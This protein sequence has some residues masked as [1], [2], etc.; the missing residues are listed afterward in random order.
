MEESLQG[1]FLIATPPLRDPHFH[2]AVVLIVE[3]NLD[4]AMGMIVNRPSGV[5]I[6]D[7]LSD[8][9][10]VSHLDDPVFIGGPVE[11][12]GLLILHNSSEIDPRAESVIPG[13]YIS[14]SPTAFENIL[15]NSDHNSQFRFR[16]YLGCAGWGPGQLESE[17]SRCDWNT[18]QAT[19]DV[20]FDDNP[21]GLWNEILRKSNKQH[22]LF[23]FDTET[24]EW[25]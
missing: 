15:L 7:A 22:Y 9:F 21:Y 17:L 13:V 11:Q 6:A 4:G 10:D 20:V 25:N 8:H 23:P 16:I 5:T 12:Q 19:T 14:N 2:K 3:H 18:F 24:P 1:H